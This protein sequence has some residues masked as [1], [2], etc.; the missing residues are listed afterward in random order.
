[1]AL[2]TTPQNPPMRRPA[3]RMRY[4]LYEVVDGE[5]RALFDHDRL[6]CAQANFRIQQKRLQRGGELVLRDETGNVCM[7]ARHASKGSIWPIGLL[8]K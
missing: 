1:M 6:D 3:N 2:S 7:F 4:Y 5:R 8:G